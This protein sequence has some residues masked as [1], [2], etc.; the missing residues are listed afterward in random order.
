VLPGEAFGDEPSA[1]RFRMATSLLYGQTDDERWEALA[2]ED[3]ASL[4][5][6]RSALDRL[7]ATLRAL[8]S[9]M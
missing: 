7:G 2:A 4:P 8:G 3:P 5:R 6:I 1:L 9:R